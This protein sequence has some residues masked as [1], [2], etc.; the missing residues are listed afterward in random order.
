MNN[1]MSIVNHLSMNS[2]LNVLAFRNYCVVGV[3]KKW[4]CCVAKCTKIV[5][6]FFL[7]K[8][9]SSWTNNRQSNTN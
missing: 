7:K 4:R 9:Q 5:C 6:Q 1:V 8:G 2:L 3:W